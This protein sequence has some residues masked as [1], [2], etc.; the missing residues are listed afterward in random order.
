MSAQWGMA[1]AASTLD[2]HA[3]RVPYLAVTESIKQRE[4]VT[5]LSS[6]ERP[7]WRHDAATWLTDVGVLGGLMTLSLTGAFLALRRT[8]PDLMEG[9][10]RGRSRP[11]ASPPAR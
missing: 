1:A 9:R 7:T 10:H 6:F 3:I 4:P 5:D 2:L 8:D 11:R